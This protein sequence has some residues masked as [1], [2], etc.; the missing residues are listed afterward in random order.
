[1]CILGKLRRRQLIYIKQNITFTNLN[2]TN[3]INTYNIEIQ[4][5]RIA[6][7]KHITVF[8]LYIQDTTNST[9]GI[10]NRHIK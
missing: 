4:L 10:V 3:N 9:N 5:V 1:M 6:I 2:I 7:N 8:N